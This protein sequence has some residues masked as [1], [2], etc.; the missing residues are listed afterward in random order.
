MEKV[1]SLL[2]D[3]ERKA[4]QILERADIE[5]NQLFEESEKAIAEMEKGIA[6]ESKI[7]I[8]ALTDRAELEIEK[9]RQHL[10]ESSEKQLKDLENHYDKDHA[11]L[12][13]KIFQSI[14]Q[15]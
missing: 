11:I 6:E 12:V 5:K 1:I 4:N 8:K 14:I 15:I 7:K 2:F 3:I 9:E 10:I 13:D